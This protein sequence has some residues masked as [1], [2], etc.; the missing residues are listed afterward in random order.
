MKH[1]VLPN[2]YDLRDYSHER[3]FGTTDPAT[4]PSEYNGDLGLDFPDQNA[5]GY[6]NGC[7]GYTQAETGQDEYRKGFEPPF[8]YEK[9]LLIENAPPNSPCLV[10]D[11]MKA[12]S[13]YGLKPRG[14]QESAA[15][16]YKRGAYF[17]VDKVGDYFDGARTA[18]WLN[19]DSRRTLSV[20]T[21]WVWGDFVDAT[22]ILAKL[23]LK[24]SSSAPWHNYKVCGW[25]TINGQVYLVIKAWCGPKWGD[26]G[27]GY[28]SRETFNRL[29][30]ISG[31]FMYLQ[32]NAIGTDVQTIKVDILELILDFAKRILKLMAS[33]DNQTQVSIQT[34]P[35]APKQPQET[36]NSQKLYD[37]AV[38]CLGRDMSP[39]N[40]APNSLAC[41]E[42]LNG[43]FKEA[44]GKVIDDGSG[45]LST[46][47]LYQR[48]K[49]DS[50][51]TQVN[52]P[53]PGDI[54]ISPTGLSYKGSA[55]GHCGLW[56][57]FDI[58]SNDSDTGKWKDNYTHQAWYDVFQKELGFPVFFFRVK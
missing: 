48:L 21:P 45:L 14:M 38:A 42:S 5:D 31:T 47:G 28:V 51:F 22:G 8:T 15:L 56:G 49:N 13:V 11:S 24:I 33:T 2:P 46:A 37:T 7:T 4:L 40:L 18:L 35:E 17:D 34:P 50:R 39:Q 30:D 36:S 57:K 20:G 1:G 6:P 58:M 26:K 10:R 16:S 27:Y 29:M 3:T 53:Q 9:T 32:R 19:S 41:A 52:D 23:P 12:T 54:V 55:H 44:F 43:V 25:K